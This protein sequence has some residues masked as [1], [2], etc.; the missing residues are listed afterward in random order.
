MRQPSQDPAFR[1]AAACSFPARVAVCC[2]A[3]A[4]AISTASSAGLEEIVVTATRRATPALETPLSLSSVGSD[5]L[6]LVGS[7]HHSE[8]LNRLPGVMIQRGSGQESLTSIRS[9]VLAGAGSC[10]AFLFLENDVPVRPTGFCNVNEMFEIN[11]EQARS[12]EVLRGP[13]TALYGSSAMHGTV[14]VI[15]ASPAQLPAQALGVDVGPDAYTRLKFAGSHAAA[16]W[17]VGVTGLYTHDGGWR[18]DSGFDEAKLNATAAGA[19]RDA[20]TRI[21]LAATWLDQQT[22]GF[23]MGQGAYRSDQQSR[24]N[25]NPE[26]YREANA[27]RLTGLI[28]PRVAGDAHLELRPYLRT[29]RMEFLQH[30]LLGKPLEQNGQESAGLMSSLTWDQDPDWTVVTGLDLELAD[31]FLRED[32]DGPTTDGS[33]AANAIRPA[34]LHYDYEVRSYVVALYAHGE[35]RFADR[36]HATAGVRA[37]SVT[38]DYDNRMLT[39]NTD[40]NGVPCGAAGCLYSRPADRTDSFL[41]LAPK[42]GLSVDLGDRMLAYAN[43]IVGFRPPEM[44]ELYRL[45]RTQRVAELDSERLDSLEVGVKGSRG[46]LGFAAALFDMRKDSV[47][48]RDSNGYNVSNGATSHRGVEYELRWRALEGVDVTGAGTYARHRYEFSRRIEGGE[49]I[50]DGNDVDTAPRQSYRAAVDWQPTARLALESEWL[51]VGEYWLDAANAHSYPGHGLL[52]LRGR[53]QVAPR[54]T[55]TLRLNNAL[56]RNYADR[57][58]YAFGS[59]RYF[60]GRGRALFAEIA[61]QRD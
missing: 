16:D 15:Q 50:V 11:T 52:N 6:Q 8:T 24:Q 10:G 40:E 44:T 12:I 29:S 47:I 57:A 48:L 58:D 7:T 59:Y 20:P 32:Q 56:D 33:P 49:Q 41:N 39:G 21:N 25:L 19:W 3:C 60:P 14:N 26:A 45:Q 18:V 54:W 27:V 28:E 35:R 51:A 53:W 38:Y 42:L 5:A 55:A 43:A 31:S 9:P 61:W 17:S 22:A 34:G 36:W 1:S 2:A 37:E 23:I 13:G 30:F 46:P 4:V